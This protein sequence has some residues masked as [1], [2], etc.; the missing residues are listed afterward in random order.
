[1]TNEDTRA[2]VRKSNL[3]AA[4]TSRPWPQVL[5]E[6]Y[7][8]GET[9]DAGPP[10]GPCQLCGDDPAYHQFRLANDRTGNTTHACLPCIDWLHSIGF[11]FQDGSSDEEVNSRRRSPL[12]P[13]LELLLVDDRPHAPDVVEDLFSSG[14]V[15]PQDL[16]FLL[17]GFDRHGI[18]HNP[19]AYAVATEVD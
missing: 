10:F 16:A 1:M 5:D 15:S 14:A 7:L 3:I 17:E 4:S 8:P 2:E 11:R 19:S 12:Q 9:T 18:R 13:V 6:W